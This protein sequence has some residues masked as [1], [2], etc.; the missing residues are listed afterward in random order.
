MS[1]VGCNDCDKLLGGK[2]IYYYIKGERTQKNI[3]IAAVCVRQVSE[4]LAKK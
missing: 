1:A 4:K 2:A 3:V